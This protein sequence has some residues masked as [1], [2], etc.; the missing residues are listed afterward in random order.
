MTWEI[1]RWTAPPKS[2]SQPPSDESASASAEN[3]TKENTDVK[4]IKLGN[5]VV[6]SDVNSTTANSAADVEMRSGPP[7]AI[8]ASS[9]APSAPQ[10]AIPAA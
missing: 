3:S 2:A 9:P 1:P 4:D 6:K 10:M 5:G 7:S 8:A